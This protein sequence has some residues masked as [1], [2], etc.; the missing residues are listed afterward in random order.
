MDV[1]GHISRVE[2]DGE[3]RDISLLEARPFSHLAAELY[4]QVC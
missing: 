4:A 2:I 3:L 1:E